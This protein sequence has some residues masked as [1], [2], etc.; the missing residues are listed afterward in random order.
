MVIQSAN[1]S[2][3]TSSN[4]HEEVA[5]V[6]EHKHVHFAVVVEYWESKDYILLETEY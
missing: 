1:S 4:L 3:G 2:V 6:E 5:I